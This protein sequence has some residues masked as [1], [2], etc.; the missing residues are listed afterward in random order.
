MVI[1]RLDDLSPVDPDVYPEFA[2]AL[3]NNQVRGHK[4]GVQW[5][6]TGLH[7]RVENR[8]YNLAQADYWE[9]QP[10]KL[11]RDNRRDV[12]LA[13]HIHFRFPVPGAKRYFVDP[14]DLDG[15]LRPLNTAAQ[16]QRVLPSQVVWVLSFVAN[17]HGPKEE[18]QRVQALR[19]MLV[20]YNKALSTPPPE[21]EDEVG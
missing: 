20:E 5:A 9:L 3:L 1:Q 7:F 16:L 21:E 12:V 4:H 14:D 19:K 6:S 10:P 13:V 17:P 2:L 15:Q 11:S 8:V 18:Y